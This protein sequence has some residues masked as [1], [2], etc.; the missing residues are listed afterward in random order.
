V[1]VVLVEG[2]D[3]AV[4]TRAVA[5]ARRLAQPGDTVLLAPACASQDIFTDYAERG[6]WYARAVRDLDQKGHS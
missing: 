4:L 6:E 5:A 2:Q 3:K 1:P